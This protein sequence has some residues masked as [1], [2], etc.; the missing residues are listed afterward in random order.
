MKSLFL[1]FFLQCITVGIW[2]QGSFPLDCDSQPV[3]TT[4]FQTNFDTLPWRSLKSTQD[5]MGSLD[6]AWCVKKNDSLRYAW[7]ISNI[8]AHRNPYVFRDESLSGPAY[9][10]S[11]S[12]GVGNF[13]FSHAFDHDSTEGQVLATPYFDISNLNSPELRFW[14]YMYGEDIDRLV[15]M[16]R[17]MNTAW[18]RLDSL[19]GEHQHG[20]EELWKEYYVPLSGMGDTVQLAF[21]SYKNSSGYDGNIAIDLVNVDQKPSCQ[22]PR[23]PTVSQ[24]QTSTVHINFIPGGDATSFEVIFGAHGFRPAKGQGQIVPT[25]ANQIKLSQL[26]PGLTYDAYIRDIC[27]SQSKSKWVGPV[28]WT[29]KCDTIFPFPFFEDFNN[30]RPDT[31]TSFFSENNIN[32]CWSNTTFSD[33]FS[34]A[35]LWQVESGT[36]N[37]PNTQHARLDKSGNGFFLKSDRRPRAITLAVNT[38]ELTSPDIDL[39][40]SVNPELSFWYYMY[41]YNPC[42]LVTSVIHKGGE[43]FI[44]T[45]VGP[46]HQNDSLPWLPRILVLDD[47]KGDTIQ[48]KFSF[49]HSLGLPSRTDVLMSID[50]FWLREKSGCALA[51]KDSTITICPAENSFALGTLLDS[52]AYGGSWMDVN[53]SGA[54]SAGQIVDL[55]MLQIDS[56]YQF[57]Y[58]IPADSNCSADSATFTLI[59]N[60]A[61]CLGFNE[62]E[63]NNIKIYPNP[64][65]NLLQIEYTGDSE[66]NQVNVYNLDGREVYS[67]RNLPENI[68]V[69]Q[70]PK[71]FYILQFI[72][73]KG[74]ASKRFVKE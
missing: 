23:F 47:Y 62:Y 44:D 58:V 1:I 8:Y 30:W 29:Q 70:W 7:F 20:F 36:K 35:Y 12:Q 51:G 43:T 11:G 22:T 14:Y 32:A 40:Q 25:N 5:R 55:T 38:S 16:A 66:I 74:V 59:R 48:L 17:E 46:T 10:H 18:Q 49:N 31:I 37:S 67:S 42:E 13:L 34:G 57:K 61:A 50:E 33:T 45:L 2:A 39:S 15:I 4:P 60:Q 65:H 9:D 64:A 27:S 21:V 53:N 63:R 68:N 3:Y 26:E 28:S 69:A 72:T 73:K 56:A 24:I 6:T 52:M 71:G 41:G 19:V 54:M